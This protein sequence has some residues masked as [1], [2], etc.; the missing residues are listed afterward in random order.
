MKVSKNSR[1][2]RIGVQTVGNQFERAGYIFREQAIS[3]YGIDAHVE[4]VEGDNATGKLIALQIKSGPSWFAEKDSGGFIFR[5]D[6]EHLSYWLEHSLPVLIV[7]C[8]TENAQCFWQA[9]TPENVVHTKKA[10]KII[11]PKIQKINAGMDVDLKHLVNKLPVHKNHTICSTEDVSHGVAKRY[12]LRIILNREHTQAEIIALLRKATA[13][14]TNCEY[15]RN[16]MTRNHWRNQPAHVVWLFIYPSAEDEKNNNFICR[17]EWFSDNLQQEFLPVSN[18]GEEIS[19]NI[20]VCWSDNYIVTSRINA[21]YTI[22]KEDFIL[23]VMKLSKLISPLVKTAVTALDTYQNNKINFESLKNALG[24]NW[25]GINEIYNL[26][27]DMGLPPYE[28]KEM[29]DRFQSL[30][31][32]AHNIYLPFSGIGK[33]FDKKQTVFNIKS[34][35]GYYDD[36]LSGFEF[37][38]KKVQ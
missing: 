27:I 1:I 23:Q 30:L 4:L 34:Q 17:S 8:D 15:H 11:V 24:K 21:Q 7:L 29:S 18:G 35:A 28:C 26:G 19:P 33:G 22:T 5:G 16:D 31:A 12:S 37:E 3:D 14:A 20:R 2:D 36:A 9:I 38:L 6:N 25:D 32:H 13:E 10:W